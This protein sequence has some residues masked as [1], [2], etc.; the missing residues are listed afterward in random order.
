MCP[1]R[2]PATKRTNAMNDFATPLP[3]PRFPRFLALACALLLAV[4]AALAPVS[5]WAAP[6]QVPAVPSRAATPLLPHLS[7]LLDPSGRLQVRDVED[8][9]SF[10]PVD[11]KNF[12]RSIPREAGTLWLRFTL[13]ARSPGTK[14]VTQLLD[15]G[16]NVPGTPTLFV[17]TSNPLTDVPQWQAFTPS[18]RSV[19]L[20]PEP[21]DVPQTVYVRLDG[22]PG[23]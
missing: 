4:C 18:Q 17:S 8:S 22:V 12:S 6:S 23:Q 13:A 9:R 5:P 19:F 14:S 11:A 3:R 7:W 20:M 2:V 21:R 1:V 16:D 15:L 10:R